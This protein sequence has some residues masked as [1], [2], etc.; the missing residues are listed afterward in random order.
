MDALG[1]RDRTKFHT[2]LIRPLID[3]DWL[4]MTIP[5]KPRSSKQRYIITEKG[6][7]VLQAIQRK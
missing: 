3:A 5:D 4:T 1:W 2:K 6:L 7:Q